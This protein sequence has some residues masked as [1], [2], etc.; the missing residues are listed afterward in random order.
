MIRSNAS[1]L[2]KQITGIT[3]PKLFHR[4]GEALKEE[5]EDAFDELLQETAQ[6]TGSTVA[7]YRMGIDGLGRGVEDTY[8]DLPDPG[9]AEA[10]FKRGDEPAINIAR[11]ANA[12][13]IPPAEVAEAVLR[14]G[15]RLIITNGSPAWERVESGEPPLRSENEGSVDAMKRFEER[16][17]NKVIDVNLGDL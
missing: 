17:A 3:L 9:S 5:F 15:R 13:A 11:A 12:G 2:A 7:S 4:C 10:A 16:I 1:V 6:Y 14:K 8:V